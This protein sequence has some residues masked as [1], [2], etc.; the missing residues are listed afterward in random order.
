M[1]D[2][3]SSHANL[4][5]NYVQIANNIKIC[6]QIEDCTQTIIIIIRATSYTKV[7]KV[8]LVENISSDFL[9]GQF[10]TLVKL[11]PQRDFYECRLAPHRYLLSL[12]TRHC[13]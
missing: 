2:P 13:I 5:T 4:H 12:L 3:T 7:L 8:E 10:Q 1:H 9:V 11:V 6:K